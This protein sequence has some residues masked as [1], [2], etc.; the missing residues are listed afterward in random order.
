MT[1]FGQLKIGD[2][3]FVRAWETL[4]SPPA[5][6]KLNETTAYVEHGGHGAETLAPDTEVYIWSEPIVLH[7]APTDVERAAITLLMTGPQRS[8]RADHTGLYH[9]IMAL[10]T[11]PAETR[12]LDEYIW[13][14]EIVTAWDTDGDG[15]RIPFETRPLRDVC[16]DDRY[17]CWTNEWDHDNSAFAAILDHKPT[18]ERPSTNLQRTLALIDDAAARLANAI[19][20][21]RGAGRPDG[22]QHY[23]IQGLGSP[24]L[25][26]TTS[27]AAAVAEYHSQMLN[28]YAGQYMDLR[29]LLNEAVP[30]DLITQAQAAE[31]AGITDQAI[32]NAI[33]DRRLRAYSDENAV[34]HRP[35]DRRVSEA[36]VR[37][38]WP[39]KRHRRGYVHE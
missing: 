29:E 7:T 38:L 20:D 24:L 21:Y 9:Y 33:R 4:D 2:R 37:R 39:T 5:L 28:I 32:N 25:N 16:R 18:G 31:I 27:L 23:T 1:T 12:S 22:D 13:G 10:A 8:P 19:C 35:G 30:S 3:F 15:N 17:V 6:Y 36:D 34:S 26:I 11:D 14:A